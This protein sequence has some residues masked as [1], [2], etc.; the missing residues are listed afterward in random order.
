[1]SWLP[2]GL[3]GGAGEDRRQEEKE[4]AGG[5][6]SSWPCHE[7]VHTF[8]L[9]AYCASCVS[10]FD[11]T[12]ISPPRWF[13]AVSELS[14]CEALAVRGCLGGSGKQIWRLV[15]MLRLPH[16]GRTQAAGFFAE[17]GLAW[18]C[19]CSTFG[20]MAGRIFPSPTSKLAGWPFRSSCFPL[21]CR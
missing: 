20:T 3:A 17:V 9:I 12:N 11:M 14:A 10:S 18:C 16:G 15:C 2:T 8:I 6:G 4:E 19:R 21:I 13:P 5:A 7:A 1:M